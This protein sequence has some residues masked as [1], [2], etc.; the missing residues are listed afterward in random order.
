MRWLLVLWALSGCESSVVTTAPDA[1]IPVVDALE[2]AVGSAEGGT[3]VRLS[4]LHV[5]S[6]LGPRDVVVHLGGSEAEVTA[7]FRGDGCDP[8]DVC[9]SELFS[10]AQC[11]RV[12]RGINA[13]KDTADIVWGPAACEEWV[14][15]T[16]PPHAPG[17]AELILQNGR[18]AV[19]GV[20]FDYEAAA[21]DDDSA[22]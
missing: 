12:C 6:E 19:G 16:T 21:D 15:F 22:G 20:Y 9:T 18:G 5:G 7:V 2:P 1:C 4:G 3:T 8:C 11:E 14:D 13:Y 17:E 10:C